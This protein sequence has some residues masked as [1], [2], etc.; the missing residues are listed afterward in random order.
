MGSGRDL[1][2]PKAPLSLTQLRTL[3]S[4]LG[5]RWGCYGHPCPFLPSLPRPPCKIPRVP[6]WAWASPERPPPLN[7]HPLH[8]INNKKSSKCHVPG[9]CF[10]YSLI[11]FTN[12]H[13]SP[14]LQKRKLRH[15]QSWETA[16]PGFKPRA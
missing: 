14:I 10:M 7:N 3:V 6:I 8:S 16:M 4:I 11:S 5:L 13:L 9:T 12:P 1:V 15:C 2:A